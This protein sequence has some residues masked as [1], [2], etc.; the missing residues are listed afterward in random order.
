MPNPQ[1]SIK[2]H[3]DNRN[4]QRWIPLPR[5]LVPGAQ[6]DL[7]LQ[8]PEAPKDGDL[9]LNKKYLEG[10]ILRRRHGFPQ[11]DFYSQSDKCHYS[12]CSSLKNYDN[13]QALK[14][15]SRQDQG[16]QIRTIAGQSPPKFAASMVRNIGSKCL[17]C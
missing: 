16:G 11:V 6:K 7:E 12:V 4:T 2:V 17:I 1:Q 8:K 15:S 13:V 14:A 3:E 5:D 9:V 10:D